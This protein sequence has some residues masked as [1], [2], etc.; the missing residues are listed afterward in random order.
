M[1]GSDELEL[2]VDEGNNEREREREG[3]YFICV[4]GFVLHIITLVSRLSKAS[5]MEE[6]AK[7]NGYNWKDC[8]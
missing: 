3:T 7:L 6:G 8:H 4:C 2:G 1:G 5:H